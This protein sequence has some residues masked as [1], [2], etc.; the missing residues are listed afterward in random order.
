[1]LLR[2][3]AVLVLMTDSS[4]GPAVLLSR[5][6]ADLSDYP[7][8]WVFPGG[9]L[10]EG[11]TD[12]TATAL[13]EAREEVGLDLR[14][15]EVVGALPPRVLLDTGFL[16]IPILA[17]VNRPVFALRANTAEV[18]AFRFIPVAPLAAEWTG[19]GAAGASGPQLGAMTSSVLA[20]LADVLAADVAQQPLRR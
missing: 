12:L 7:S 11:D 15:I 3:S 13:R 16:V 1:M 14:N 10:E 17:W 6:A 18:D 4:D 2:Q 20:E 19:G 8:Q 9:S 5:R